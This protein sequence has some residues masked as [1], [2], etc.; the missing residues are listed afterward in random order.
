MK[1][2]TEYTLLP[3]AYS[4]SFFF[5]FG[6]RFYLFIRFSGMPI[7]ATINIL[8]CD[9][10]MHKRDVCIN[11]KNLYPTDILQKNRKFHKKIAFVAWMPPRY[12]AVDADFDTR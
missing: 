9:D 8:C 10:R 6:F 1:N 11:R 7:E 3:I 5:L 12:N 2:K 4:R